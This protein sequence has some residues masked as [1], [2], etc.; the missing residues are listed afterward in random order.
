LVLFFGLKPDSLINTF[1]YD[2]VFIKNF[3]ELSNKVYIFF[4]NV[5]I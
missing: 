1:Y 2:L 4:I 5:S 3:I